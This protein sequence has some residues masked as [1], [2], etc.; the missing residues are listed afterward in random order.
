[1][2]IP[3]ASLILIATSLC[4]DSQ[5]G[6]SGT[7]YYVSAG[8]G[9]DSN[10]GLSPRSAWQTIARVNSARLKPGDSV[11]FKRGDL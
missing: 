6:K 2:L 5:E 3:I 1:M 10:D 11:L 8:S 4:A 9:K 7:I